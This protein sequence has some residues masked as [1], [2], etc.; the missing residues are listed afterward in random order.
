MFE[1][2]GNVTKEKTR[3]HTDFNFK[4]NSNDVM[5]EKKATH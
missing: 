4:M 2:L 1:M 3:N 5:D